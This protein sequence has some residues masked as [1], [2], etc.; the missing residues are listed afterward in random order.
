MTRSRF[1]FLMT[2]FSAI[3]LGCFFVVFLSIEWTSASC[4]PGE[5]QQPYAVYGFPLPYARWSGVSSME[6]VYL[7]WILIANVLVTSGFIFIALRLVR[8]KGSG[9]HV[10]W[11][12]PLL[13]F[14]L[15]IGSAVLSVPV[16]NLGYGYSDV[17]LTS[18]RPV[19]IDFAFGDYECTPSLYWFGK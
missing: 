6:F 14:S 5:L 3:A 18:F 15:F 12:F 11:A 4:G 7:R 10:L 19:D 16:A 9:W 2:W 8:L 13:I 1:Q 17:P